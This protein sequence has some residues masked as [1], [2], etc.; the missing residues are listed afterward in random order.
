[1]QHGG[2]VK[3]VT[4][5]LILRRCEGVAEVK[6]MSFSLP[7]GGDCSNDVKETRGDGGLA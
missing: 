6:D 5:L 4:I 3:L 7:L 2:S 1:M